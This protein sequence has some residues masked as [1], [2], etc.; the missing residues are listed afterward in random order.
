MF[1]L[2]WWDEESFS[3]RNDGTVA[4]DYKSLRIVY[5]LL[6]KCNRRISFELVDERG[7]VKNNIKPDWYV[8]D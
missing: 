7:N 2:S 4:G 1:M 3:D 6:K 8:E 5:L